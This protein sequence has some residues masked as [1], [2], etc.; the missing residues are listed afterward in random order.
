MVELDI[1]TAFFLFIVI[2]VLALMLIAIFVRWIINFKNE[3]NYINRE[4]YRSC[5]REKKYWIAK[6]RR[7]MLSII[8]FIRY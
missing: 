8:P 5:G 3:L 2:S 4:I 1:V 6:K 7:L